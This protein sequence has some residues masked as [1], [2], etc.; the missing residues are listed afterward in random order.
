MKNTPSLPRSEAVC[1]LLSLVNSF[2]F[3]CV[4]S[5]LCGEKC[6][7]ARGDSHAWDLRGWTAVEIC[8]EPG[9]TGL[10]LDP[11]GGDVM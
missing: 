1:S 4:L 2:A 3:L 7:L 9:G 10:G 5:V 11:D 6:R 8:Q